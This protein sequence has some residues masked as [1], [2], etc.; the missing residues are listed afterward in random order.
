[1][2]ETEKLRARV[3]R[4]LGVGVR[5]APDQGRH[6][7]LHRYADVA[8]LLQACVGK[9][10]TDPLQAEAIERVEAS[11]ERVKSAWEAK[12]EQVKAW[13][14][15]QEILV[16]NQRADLL[17]VLDVAEHESTSIHGQPRASLAG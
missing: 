4:D 6:P 15:L 17:I 3:V 10:L 7:L 16:P 14:P 9:L 11:A 5:S 2:T 8:I 12:P 1:M 13:H